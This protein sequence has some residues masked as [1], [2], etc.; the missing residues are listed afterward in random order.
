MG[1][2]EELETRLLEIQRARAQRLVQRRRRDVR[3]QRLEL[4]A[5]TR[6]SQRA[7]WGSG[8]E[9]KDERVRLLSS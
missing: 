3:D 2:I 4:D 8:R 5:S 9:F 6:E 1:L 7:G